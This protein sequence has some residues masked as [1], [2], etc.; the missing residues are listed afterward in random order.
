MTHGLTT[1]STRTTEYTHK[2]G[3]VSDNTRYLNDATDQGVTWVESEE[4]STSVIT[5]RN[6]K[7]SWYFTETKAFINANGEKKTLRAEICRNAYNHQSYVHYQVWSDRWYTK[8]D[9]GI[10]GTPVEKISY[11]TPLCKLDTEVFRQTADIV[12]DIARAYGDLR[13]K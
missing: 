9:I 11:V 13:R 5:L 2:R 10:E 7:Q 12:W 8:H 1:H 3:T 4:N 6:H